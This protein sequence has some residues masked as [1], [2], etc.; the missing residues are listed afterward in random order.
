M[1]NL[2]ED[3]M[4]GWMIVFYAILFMV[5]YTM[6][7]ILASA[8]QSTLWPKD[9]KLESEEFFHKIN[10]QMQEEVDKHGHRHDSDTSST[11]C[12]TCGK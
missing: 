12:A 10:K 9:Y 8:V 2:S 7:D 4:I 5:G 11:I 1:K 6:G 3:T